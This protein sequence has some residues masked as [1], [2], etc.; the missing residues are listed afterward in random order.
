MRCILTQDRAQRFDLAVPPLLRCALIRLAAAEHRLVL[1]THHMV[2]DGWS[3]PVLM[4]ELLT[5]YAQRGDA[6]ALPPVTPYRDYLAWLSE[7]D[8]GAAVAAWREA[9]AGLEE[10]TH[11]APRAA[12]RA[13]VDPEQLLFAL[14]ESLT[15]VLTR[16]ARA[17]GLTFNT[18][19][20]AAWGL[21]LG[22]LT[23]RS[24]VVFGVTVAG[25]PPEVTGIERMV[26]LFINTLPLRLRLAPGKPLHLLLAELQEAQS[27]LMAHQHLGLAEIQNLTGLGE[28]FDTLVVFEN[29]PVDQAGLAAEVGGLRLTHASG[30]DAAHYPLALGVIPG[31]RIQMH[32]DYRPDLF[33]RGSAEALTGR[34]VRLLEA[35]AAEPEGPIGR[36]DVLSVEERATILREWN[37]TAH[38]VVPTTVPELFAAQVAK[39][40]DALAVVFGE[41]GSPMANWMRAPTSW[42]II[43]AGS[44]SA[45]KW[46]WGCAWNARPR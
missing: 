3:R 36:L 8:R 4:Q 13:P 46:W 1:T 31:E 21:L 14:S 27:R 45:P 32:L 28:L 17:L 35:A 40:P 30:H 19:I 42:R 7:Q 41:D 38:A 23:G 24:D 5:L 2:M 6:A 10:G 22:R 12:G 26:G 25:R 11:L 16:Q 29:Y 18:I 44:A 9:L 15:A 43:C 39:A 34:F 33:E 20:Q 37:D